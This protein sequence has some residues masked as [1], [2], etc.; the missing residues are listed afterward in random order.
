M[1]PHPAVELVT[2]IAEDG[3]GAVVIGAI[4]TPVSA[5]AL[6]RL[7]R[8]LYPCLTLFELETAESNLDAT[9][10]NAVESGSLSYGRD[11][12]LITETRLRLKRKASEIRSR[13]LQNSSSIWRT[14]L[15]FHPEL[16]SE[17]IEW[18]NNAEKLRWDILAI[19]E[20]DN[21]HRYDIELNRRGNAANCPSIASPILPTASSS[22][23]SQARA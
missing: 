21:Q 3:H 10:D 13:S 17:I 14:Y 15:G 7:L 19:V 16:L 11:R 18:S 8:L 2:A 1:S 6:Y 20:D 22:S 4:I 9:F 23:T 5:F 12:D